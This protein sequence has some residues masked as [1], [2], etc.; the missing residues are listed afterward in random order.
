MQDSVIS[1]TAV[2]KTRSA[3]K[4]QPVRRA[5]AGIHRWVTLVVGVALLVIMTAGV[6]LLWGAESFRANNSALYEPTTSAEPLTAGQALARVQEAHPDF[7]A[8]N[9]INDKGMFL[10]SDADLNLVY[11]V[12]PGSGKITGSGHYY[13]GFQGLM[14]NLHGYGL[15][16]PNYPGYV[17]FMATPIPSFGIAQLNGMTLGVALVGILGLVLVFLALSGLILWWPSIKHFGSGFRIRWKGLG[18]YTRDRDLHKVAGLV[19][20]PFLL[21]WGITG[22]AAQFPFIEQGLMAL[23]GGHTDSSNVKALN[24]DFASNK[25]AT[26]DAK[27]IS[28]DAAAVAALAVVPGKISNSTLADPQ[29]PTSAYLFRISQSSEDPF[30]QA[31]FAG[32]AWVYVDKYD[33]SH[34]KIV[35]DGNGATPQ[36]NFYENV[37]YPSHFGWYVNGWWRIIWALFGLTPLLLAITGFSTWLTRTRRGRARQARRRAAAAA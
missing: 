33:A 2:A 15:S 9:V 34:T 19:A 29:D 12:D 28:L 35:W 24:W 25:P 16:S 10:V 21:M 17:P 11:G 7:A 37:L 36:N 27:G 1:A 20:V 8:G 31:A 26:P 6:P 30:S 18:A 23:T 13:G 3:P 5:I 4:P 14:E 32:N 22:A